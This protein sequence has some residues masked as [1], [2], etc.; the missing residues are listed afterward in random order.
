MAG[1]DDD[2]E[3]ISAVVAYLTNEFGYIVDLIVGH[4]RGVVASIRW[5]CTA[6]EAQGVRAFVNASGRYRMDVSHTRTRS[7]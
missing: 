3:D 2:A 6:K 4:S 7:L 1:F 5:M